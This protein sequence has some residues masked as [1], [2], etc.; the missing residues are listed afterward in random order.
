MRI[1]RHL[2]ITLTC[3]ALALTATACGSSSKHADTAAGAVGSAGPVS[4]PAAP[5]TAPSSAAP[6]TAAPSTPAAAPTPAG[7]DLSKMTGN[8]IEKQAS[9]ALGKATSLK[10][11]AVGTDS[12]DSIE[13][14]LSLD[15]T[16]DC[17]GSIAMGSKGSFQILSTPQQTWIQP[18]AKFWTTM[19]GAHGAEAA[20]LFKGRWMTGSKD[21]PDLKSLAESCNLTQFTGDMNQDGDQAT[22]TGADTVNGQPT[23]TLHIKSTDGTSGD[24]WVAAQGTPYPLKAN[25]TNGKLAFSNFDQPVVV[26][27]PSADQV[28]DISKLKAL[29][30]A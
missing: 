9:D 8:Q 25:T 2:G 27:A 29:Q 30:S 22:K 23:V 16:G 7:P 1:H 13:M 17:S 21:D 20:E 26:Q 28:I 3:A 15:T 11:D 10:L 12:G 19:G 18:D 4:T 14:H 24:M 6:T 5:S